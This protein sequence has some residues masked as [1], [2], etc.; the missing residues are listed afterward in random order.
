LESSTNGCGRK[1]HNEAH[2]KR[3]DT[4]T[5]NKKKVTPRDRR[6]APRWR[7]PQQAGQSV[8][9]QGNMNNAQGRDNRRPQ[10]KQQERKRNLKTPVK[11]RTTARP[12]LHSHA[13]QLSSPPETPHCEPAYGSNHGGRFS[14]PNSAP[15]DGITSRKVFVVHLLRKMP[16]PKV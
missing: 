5:T 15:N 13:N 1:N 2:K 11:T 6:T 7:A 9:D 16:L 4:A 10:D 8:G 12:C 3:H 14:K